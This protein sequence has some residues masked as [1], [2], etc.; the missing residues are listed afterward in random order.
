MIC[1]KKSIHLKEF[2]EGFDLNEMIG[3]TR[4]VEGV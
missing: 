1:F 3:E 4:K 2:F